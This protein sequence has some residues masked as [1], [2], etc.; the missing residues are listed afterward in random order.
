METVDSSMLQ[1]IFLYT[2][3][4]YTLR[5]LAE[6]WNR[7]RMGVSGGALLLGYTNIHFTIVT[8]NLKPPFKFHFFETLLLTF[9]LIM[10]EHENRLRMIVFIYST[11]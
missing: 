10:K 9:T 4:N 5:M 6:R 1:R 8:E 11:A 2:S 7:V 3:L